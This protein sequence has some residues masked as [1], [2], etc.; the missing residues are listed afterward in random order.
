MK[1]ISLYVTASL[2]S[3]VLL[4]I[5][6]DEEQKPEDLTNEVNKNG[7]IETSVT[8]EHLDSAHDVIVTKHAVWAWGSNASSFEHRDTVPALGSAP[9]TVK[10]VAG[11]DKTVEAKKEYEIFITVK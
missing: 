8:V 6:C 11:Y 4:L 5:S 7:A 3:A 9:T 1:N 10:D 2:L